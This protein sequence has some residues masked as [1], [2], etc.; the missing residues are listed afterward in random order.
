MDISRLAAEYA[1][2]G[3]IRVPGL[4]SAEKIEELRAA[5]QH[6]SETVFPTLPP[7]DVVLE[8]DG[9]SVRNF[10]RMEKHDRYFETLT[11][12]PGVLAL[13]GALVHGDPVAMAVESFNKPAR[14]GSAVPQHQDNAYF[15]YSP[16]DALTVWIAVDEVTEENGPIHYV[17]GSHKG[18]LQPHAPSRVAGNSMGL[19]APVACTDPYVGLL[20]PGDALIHHSETIHYSA[21]NRSGRSRLGLL[22]VYRGAH[23]VKDPAL[24]N[25]YKLAS[26]NN[27]ANPDKD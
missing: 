24:L 19:A 20:A 10:W 15:C 11:R 26:L 21:P 2:D 1:R 12:V 3:V 4:F 5:L 9:K 23:C 16:P 6:Y 8:Q 14:V 27:A 18:G 22:I 25:A 17:R 13:V 7:E